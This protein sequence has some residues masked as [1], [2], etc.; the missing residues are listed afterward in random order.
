MAEYLPYG[1]SFEETRNRVLDHARETLEAEQQRLRYGDYTG[2]T[3]WPPARRLLD[4]ALTRE[5]RNQKREEIS[6]RLE[7]T[8]YRELDARLAQ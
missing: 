8:F 2:L 4:S 6:R 3:T 1:P 7:E 5:E